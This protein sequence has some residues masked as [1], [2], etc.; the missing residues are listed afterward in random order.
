MSK[1]KKKGIGWEKHTLSL[2]HTFTKF[3]LLKLKKKII[4]ILAIHF[5]KSHPTISPF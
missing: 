4:F 1:K 2:E 3:Y 5:F